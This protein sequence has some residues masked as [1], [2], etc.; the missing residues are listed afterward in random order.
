MEPPKKDKEKF[1]QEK[2]LRRIRYWSHSSAIF[3]LLSGTFA[4]IS[5]IGSLIAALP[6]L[7]KLIKNLFQSS[8]LLGTL[9]YATTSPG[10][11]ITIDYRPIVNLVIM[12]AI[13]IAFLWSL[14][15]SLHSKNEQQIHTASDINK[16]ILGFLIGSG[17]SYLG[18]E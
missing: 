18:L 5:L 10:T 15:V 14:G 17:K 9:A 12:L 3:T 7:N 11:E 1:F 16:L 4:V 13:G 2:G 6:Q 8:G